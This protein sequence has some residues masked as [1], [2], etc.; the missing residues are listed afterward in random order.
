MKALDNL[1]VVVPVTSNAEKRSLTSP[2]CDSVEEFAMSTP[3]ATNVASINLADPEVHL[4]G[5]H[6]EL[7][8]ILRREAPVHYF[9]GDAHFQPFWSITRYEDVMH[10]SRNPQLFSSEG[11]ISIL[12]TMDAEGGYGSGD[13]PPA[14]T[15]A[16]KMLIMMDP[17]RHV[18]LRRLVNKGFTPRAVS[19][20]ETKVREITRG[21]LDRVDGKGDIDFVVE[22]AAQLPLAVICSMMGVPEKDFDLM[23]RITNKILGAGDPEYQ[24]EVP[25]E[26]RG[27]RE[28]ARLTGQSG[29]MQAFGYFSQ[30]LQELRAGKR[31]D[32]IAS[33]LVDSEI[34]GEKLSDEEV[35]LFCFLLILAGNETTRNAI[36]GGMLVLSDHPEQKA[37]LASDPSL[38]PIAVEELL[39]WTSPV[40]HMTRVAIANTEIHGQPIAA[41]ERVCMW[42]PSVNR[43]EDIF[44]DPYR[45]DI[46][47]T[48]NDHLAFGIGEHFCLGAGFARLELRV[49]FEEL[50]ARFPKAEVSGPPER[51]RSNFLGG[52]KHLPVTLGSPR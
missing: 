15:G 50:L 8:R 49:M 47:R 30:V 7:L 28:G 44:P 20:M 43:D 13:A 18:R 2:E 14:F 17:P 27:T 9:P 34:D 23:F 31:G 36:S 25:P 42:Y 16:A 46:T 22:L 37:M 51:L 35:L 6:H 45:F 1:C 11:G 38:M 39:R 4:R 24:D 10:V 32:D 3:A 52:I 26:L 33:I 40:T 5:E 48:P 21:L 12:P 19:M 41:G 29:F